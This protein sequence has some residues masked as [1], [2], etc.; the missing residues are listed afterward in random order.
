MSDWLQEY[1]DEYTKPQEPDMLGI[2]RHLSYDAYNQRQATVPRDI[3]ADRLL[4]ASVIDYLNAAGYE[5]GYVAE[6]MR[7]WKDRSL[8]DEY[9]PEVMRDRRL[10]RKSVR[11][12]EPGA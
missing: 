10:W 1:V 12:R 7:V 9:K 11:Y 3:G 8:R 5:P 2:R 6:F 4:F